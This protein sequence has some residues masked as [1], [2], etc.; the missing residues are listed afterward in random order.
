MWP[1]TRG[2]GG[3]NTQARGARGR[4]RGGSRYGHGGGYEEYTGG[5]RNGSGD[6]GRFHPYNHRS[7]IRCFNCNGQGHYGEECP[8]QRQPNLDWGRDSE[9]FRR[10][11][12]GGPRGRGFSRGGSG[13]GPPG[14]VARGRHRGM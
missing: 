8:S 13:N 3:S 2:R 10:G 4:D 7:M 12:N 11:N 5:Y 14:G 1:T 9:R 6:G